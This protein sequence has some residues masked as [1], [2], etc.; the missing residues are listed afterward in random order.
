MF[1]SSRAEGQREGRRGIT[2]GWQPPDS[3]VPIS[4]WGFALWEGAAH[5]SQGSG[6]YFP[7][8][9]HAAGMDRFSEL[10]WQVQLSPERE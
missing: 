4:A 5:L 8:K 2:W 10:S 9:M 7:L 3:K 6:S 1:P